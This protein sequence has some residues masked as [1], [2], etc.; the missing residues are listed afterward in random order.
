M[1]NLIKWMSTPTRKRRI[2]DAIIKRGNVC[3]FSERTGKKK[4]TRFS[5]V[6]SDIFNVCD[7]EKIKKFRGA[8]VE[9]CRSYNSV[10]GVR[11]HCYGW[12]RRNGSLRTFGG[13]A[14]TEDGR[15]YFT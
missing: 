4:D 3:L 11:V 13:L 5:F 7:G 1:K 12:I 10:H 6:N 15:N 2:V 8:R 9:V 14:Q